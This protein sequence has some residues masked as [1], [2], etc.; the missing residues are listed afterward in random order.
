MAVIFS[1]IPGLE[2]ADS[3]AEI[4]SPWA[5]AGI[6]AACVAF[7]AAICVVLRNTP[8]S[9]EGAPSNCDEIPPMTI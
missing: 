9:K 2:E 3:F 5:Y 4:L 7:V 8:F 1:K 6:L